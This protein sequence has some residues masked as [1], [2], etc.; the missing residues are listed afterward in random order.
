VGVQQRHA[1]SLSLSLSL[2]GRGC[3]WAPLRLRC[4]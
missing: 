1:V 4:G 2:S 3:Q